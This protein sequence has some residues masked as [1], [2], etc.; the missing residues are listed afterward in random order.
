MPISRCHNHW[1]SAAELVVQE[2]HV[3]DASAILVPYSLSG[4]SGLGAGLVPWL[5]TGGTLYLHHPTSLSNLA[6]HANEI[7]ADVVMTPGP[8]AQTMDRQLKSNDCTVLAVWNISAPHPTAFCC[9]TP[10]CRSACRR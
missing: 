6:D 7:G 10:N 3:K 4:L 5:K 1:S 8:L 2:A 9:S